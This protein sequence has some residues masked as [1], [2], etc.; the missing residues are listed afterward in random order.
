M[1]DQQQCPREMPLTPSHTDGTEIIWER[2]KHQEFR[3]HGWGSSQSSFRKN[4]LRVII[5]Q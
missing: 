3:E 4:R 2:L 1:I 5:P